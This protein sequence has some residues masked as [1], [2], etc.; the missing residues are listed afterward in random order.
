MP[1][2]QFHISCP[3]RA[4]FCFARALVFEGS[5]IVCDPTTNQAEWVPVRGMVV[6]LSPA[7]ERSALTLCNLVPCD[8]EE[9]EESMDRFGERRD[10][11][12]AVGG[13]AEEDP[14]Q[15]GFL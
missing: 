3:S 4:F 10:A 11:G 8:E 7:E 1:S 13:S 15:E 9:P 2:M 14:S 5:S 12:N 6:D